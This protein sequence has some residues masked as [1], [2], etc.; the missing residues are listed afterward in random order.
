[1]D[2]LYGTNTI[3]ISSDLLLRGMQDVLS[4]TV[5]SHIKSLELVWNPQDL[6]IK[7]IFEGLQPEQD[8]KHTS[9]FLPSLKHLR[10]CLSSLEYVI[11]GVTQADGMQLRGIDF[12]AS[13]MPRSLD[14]VLVKIAPPTADVTVTCQSYEWFRRVHSALVESLGRERAQL[15]QSEFGGPK[16][17]R[18]ISSEKEEGDTDTGPTSNPVDQAQNSTRAQGYWIHLEIGTIKYGV[19]RKSIVCPFKPHEANKITAEEDWYNW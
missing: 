19:H 11:T 18:C 1:M 7:K 3:Q 16:F 15:H 5:L 17:W 8:R 10:I 4:S 9:P 14:S 13:H 2:V 6:H 12:L